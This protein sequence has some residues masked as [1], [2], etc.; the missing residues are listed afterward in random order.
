MKLSRLL[1][2]EDSQEAADLV[3][4]ILEYA[5]HVVVHKTTGAEAL[6]ALQ[7]EAF[8]GIL[9]DYML[10]D[11]DGLE[12]CRIVRQARNQ[13]PIILTTAYQ[14]RLTPEMIGDAGVTA[15]VPKPISQNILNT[16]KAYVHTHSMELVEMNEPKTWIQRVLGPFYSE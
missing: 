9:L 5:Q 7:S 13:V 4:A 10:P 2:V 16:I 14:D 8:D 6:K 12:F 1:L 11:M 15:F 3:I